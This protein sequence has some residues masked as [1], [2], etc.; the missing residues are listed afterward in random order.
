MKVTYKIRTGM[1]TSLNPTFKCFE[2]VVTE[3]CDELIKM[4]GLLY[5]KRGGYVLHT[6]DENMITNIEN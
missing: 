4:G 5:M 6:I 1:G 2:H 3:F